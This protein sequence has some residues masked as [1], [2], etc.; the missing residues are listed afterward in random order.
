MDR[1]APQCDREGSSSLLQGARVPP[2]SAPLRV[3]A[4]RGKL[5]RRK[6]AGAAWGLPAGRGQGGLVW[7]VRSPCPSP[8]PLPG[9]S[10]GTRGPLQ[11]WGRGAPPGRGR[12][13]GRG[14]R[15]AQEIGPQESDAAR[16][17][18]DKCAGANQRRGRGAGPRAS[19]AAPRA[20]PVPSRPGPSRRQ[21]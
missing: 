20:R 3:L 7:A 15:G 11:P 10:D 17:Y 19:P 14:P 13:G 21:P 4:Q 5:R 18:K 16:P 2:N 1:E 6:G 12:G 9:G 8:R